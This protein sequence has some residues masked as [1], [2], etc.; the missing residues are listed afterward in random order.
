MPAEVVGEN[1]GVGVDVCFEHSGHGRPKT[2]VGQD[3]AERAV[4]DL[5]AGA[6]KPRPW[7]DVGPGSR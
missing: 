7:R 6:V 2:R 1:F 5:P 3:R 4:E